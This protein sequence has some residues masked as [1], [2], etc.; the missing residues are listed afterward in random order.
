MNRLLKYSILL[1]V[2]FLVMAAPTCEDE[3]SQ[4]DTRMNRIERLEMVSN[5]FTSESLSSRN[6]E[7]FEFKAVEKLMD[8]ADYLEIIYSEG[9]AESFREQ[10]RQNIT[11][12]FNTSENSEAALI[13]KNISGS[14]NSYRIR[15]DPVDIINPLHRETDTRYTGSM[16]YDEMI[17]G[18][19]STDTILISH[20]Q[21]TIGI[22]LQMAYKDFG[23]NSLL[24]WEVLLGEITPGD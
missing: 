21:K 18:I 17:L 7:V 1:A 11:G 15:I 9:F 10:A 14:Y 23:Q 24:V 6:L 8:Y 19:S 2:C 12:F 3:I 20:S 22:I 4:A 5:D 16:S 13:L